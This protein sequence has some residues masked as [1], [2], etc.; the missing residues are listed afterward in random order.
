MSFGMA[1]QVFHLRG[2]PPLSDYGG[3]TGAKA[4]ELRDKWGF[5]MPLDV[6]RLD[7]HYLFSPRSLNRTQ[8]LTQ[9][10]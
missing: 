4:I 2:S 3:L 10:S 9:I 6:I 8:G 5:V 7:K 1:R